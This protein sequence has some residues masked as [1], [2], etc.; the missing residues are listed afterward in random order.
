MF[1]TITLQ[2]NFWN[3]SPI[4]DISLNKQSILQI[5]NFESNKEKTISFEHN[6]VEQKNELVIERK[7]KTIHDTAVSSGKITMDSVV[8]IRDITMD[9]IS[10]K[11][12][13]TMASFYPQYPE[14]WYT[15]Q[16]QMDKTPP[17]SYSY[18]TALHHN[19]QWRLQF[20]VPIH[21]WF[22]QNINVSI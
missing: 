19:G 7:G 9:K 6:V 12:L 15:E 11:P 14:P 20:E 22:F 16:K 18:T 17:E 10:V 21:V 2:T 3:Q 8:N 5:S 4:T 1:F 13:L